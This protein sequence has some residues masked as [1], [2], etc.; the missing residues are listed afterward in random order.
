MAAVQVWEVIRVYRSTTLE[1]SARSPP[2]PCLKLSA[3]RFALTRAGRGD[4]VPVG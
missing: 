1:R 4:D 3:K 2:K